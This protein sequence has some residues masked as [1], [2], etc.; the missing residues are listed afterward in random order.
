MRKIADSKIVAILLTFHALQRIAEWQLKIQSVLQALVFPEEVVHGH[1][2]RFI[3]HRRMRARLLRVIYE[4]EGRMPVV[5]RY[6]PLLR[7]ATSKEARPMKI[8]YSPDADVLLIRL[9]EGKPSDSKD[10]AEGIIVH[11]SAKGQPLEIEI[12]DASKVVQKKDIEIP[13]GSAFLA[14]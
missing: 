7:S 8:S 10:I 6:I 13:L 5:I 11:L 2:E 1:R 9:R 12:L 4:Y 3:A 14:A